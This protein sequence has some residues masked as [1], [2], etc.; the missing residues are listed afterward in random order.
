MSNFIVIFICLI[1]GIF[2]KKIRHFPSQTAQALN[3]FIIYL[4]MPALVISLVP[5]LLVTMDWSSNWW[6]PV[7]MPWACFILS[8]FLISFI[9][10]KRGWRDAKTGALILVVGL[11]NTS[12]VGYPLLEALIG[13]HAVS[14]GIFVD[15]PGSFLVLSSLGVIVAALYSG[16]KITAGFV[17]K[18]VFT[19]PPFIC[20]LATIIWFFAWGINH[21]QSLDSIIPACSIIASTLVPLALFTVGFQLQLDMAILKKCWRPLTLILSFL[22]SVRIWFLTFVFGFSSLM[23]NQKLY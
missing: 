19:F 3:A 17:V 4:S 1:A 18:R 2:C 23:K 12:Y 14:V 16:A 15:Q 10:K 22:I 13:P 6:L 5:K 8:Y 20:L 21:P 9:G 11:G 7:S